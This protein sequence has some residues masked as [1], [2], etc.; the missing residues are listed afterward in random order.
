VLSYLP[1]HLTAYERC[2]PF[3]EWVCTW[4]SKESVPLQAEDWFV[5]GHD[6][7]SGDVG[8]DNHWRPFIQSGTLLWLPPPAAA[9]VALEELRKARIKRHNLTHVFICPKLMTPL[10]LKQPFKATDFLV[11]V[12]AGYPHWPSAMHESV[13]IAFCLPYSV[14]E[15]WCAARTPKVL[16]VRRRVQKMFETSDLA[17]GDLLREFLVECRG[18]P[19]LSRSV[20]RKVLFFESSC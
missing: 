17:A 9:D 6:I 13:L 4:V 2:K 16:S 1:F 11:E 7:R 10:W 19:Q 5:R 15:P 8:D 3:W 18:I 12:P 20:V 14:H